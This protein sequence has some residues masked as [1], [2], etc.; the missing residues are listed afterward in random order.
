MAQAGAGKPLLLDGG[1]GGVGRELS[2]WVTGEDSQAE[3]NLARECQVRASGV[4]AQWCQ[5]LELGLI[6]LCGVTLEPSSWWDQA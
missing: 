4:D 3:G 5:S 1:M 2:V 6:F